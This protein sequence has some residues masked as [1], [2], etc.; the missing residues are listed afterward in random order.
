MHE[1]NIRTI[2]ILLDED[3]RHT[4]AEAILPHAGKTFIGYGRARRNP[5]D[6]DVPKIGEEIAMARA[7]F[8]LAHQ[9]MGA[10]ADAIEDF[11]GAPV[12]LHA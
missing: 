4:E 2:E 11:E 10:A 6:P 9:L 8:D 7:L 1:S 3:E 12:H 5:S